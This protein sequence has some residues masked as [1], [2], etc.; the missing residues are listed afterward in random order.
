ME[1]EK[2]VRDFSDGSRI[3]TYHKI[4]NPD[5]KHREDGP[6]VIS[7]YPNGNIEY[8]RHFINN[9]RHKTDGP[10][11]TYYNS[12]G[13]IQYEIWYKNGQ[14]HNESGPSYIIY[15]QGIPQT[16]YYRQNGRHHREDGPAYIYESNGYKCEIYFFNGIKTNK[17]GPSEIRNYSDGGV[18][19][20]FRDEYGCLNNKYKPSIIITNSD[21]E[22]K[23]RYFINGKELSY[24]EWYKEYG[25]KLQLK[26]TPMGDLYK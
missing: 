9:K 10:E 12:D 15:N 26:G 3:V 24:E 13:T 20:E 19:L 2:N 23:N 22:V 21:G 8:Y 17:N 18:Y 6:A 16:I 25:W 14:E 5:V 7:Y 1:I 4:G 11:C